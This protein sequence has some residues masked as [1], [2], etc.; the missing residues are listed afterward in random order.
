MKYVILSAFFKT[1]L[2]WKLALKNEY[3]L[4]LGEIGILDDD[5]L[6]NEW[7]TFHTPL[8]FKGAPSFTFGGDH[9]CINADQIFE[10]VL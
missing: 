8:T 1:S 3:I 10:Q 2:R 4:C 6:K 9:A 5:Y 7:N